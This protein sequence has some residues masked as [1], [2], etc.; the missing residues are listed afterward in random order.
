MNADGTGQTRLTNSPGNDFDPAFSPNGSK[1]AFT[2]YRDGNAEIY[3]MNA[4]G[5][6]QTNLTNSAGVEGDPAFSLDGRIA[7]TSNRDGNFE[8]YVMNAD[9]TN[10]TRLTNIPG[11]N[12]S[13]AFSPNGSKIAFTSATGSFS[14]VVMMNADGTGLTNLTNNGA[15]DSYPSWGI[16]TV[17][18]AP[19]A[20]N[21]IY[22]T[23]EDT[24]L[25]VTAPGVLAN[26]TDIDGD[27]L[28]AQLL[29]V[30]ANGTLTLNSNGSFTYTPA[31]N[32]NGPDS[33][34]YR[35]S[36]GTGSS[37]TATVTITVIP[38]NDAPVITAQPIAATKCEGEDVTFSVAATD[39]T[40][41]QWQVNEGSGFVDLDNTAPYS[42][43]NTATLTITGAPAALN[44]N[45]YRVIVNGPPAATSNAAT[46]T[47]NPLI[48]YYQDQD[49]DTYGDAASTQQSCS[50]PSGYVTR[51]DDC[52]DA[53]AAIN[54][55][56]AEVCDGID[57]NCNGQI[58]EGLPQSTY[59]S[60]SDGDGFGDPATAVQ[61]CS[62]PAGYVDR[63]GDCNDTNA[64]IN[65][66]AAEV[67]DGID[68]NCNGQ[69][70]EGL[71]SVTT[72]AV[73]PTSNVYTGGNPNI[74]YLGYGPQSVKLEASGGESYK[75]SPSKGLSNANIA[76]PVFT[77]SKAGSYPFTVTATNSN[78]CEATAS[79]TIIVIDVRSGKKK[80]KV[81]VCHKGKTN[82]IAPSAVPAHLGHGDMLGDCSSST[83]QARVSS[84]SHS[85]EAEV[86]DQPLIRSYPNP[87]AATT[88]VQFAFDQEQDYTLDIYDTNGR[89]IRQL[90]QG[91]ARAGE[92][93]QVEWQAANVPFGVYI[94]RL[95]SNS[96]VQHLRIVRE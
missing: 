79:V 51:A 18:D 70:D 47:V 63:P 34:T 23:N 5:T 84:Q 53:S 2:S 12:F 93:K 92:L 13:P 94:L 24:P 28:T 38:V 77:P 7:F 82:S 10:P 31:A 25:T 21:D 96:G 59:F 89:F 30:P 9:G 78:G 14:E 1:I 61:G 69:I 72:I 22:S 85:I 54:P 33:F 58:D 3:V 56:A 48:T 16:L 29:A 67:C 60:D 39:A 26:D 76:D 11:S 15:N 75:W 20:V 8:I 46:L 62:P 49:G 73:I 55:E 4:N 71:T 37:N 68:N 88:T 43:V 81:D 19:V 95:S 36:D 45:Q 66:D 41:Y 91:K 57:N 44:G 80:D 32:Y 83:T 35:A 50:Q 64:A 27:A 52:N 40:G 17:N 65:P 90:S 87:F 74:I 42:G 6:G 86:F